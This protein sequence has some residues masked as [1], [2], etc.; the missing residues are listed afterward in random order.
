MQ[1]KS[2]W[3]EILSAT[4]LHL[5]DVSQVWL[6]KACLGALHSQMLYIYH[7]LLLLSSYD[8]VRKETEY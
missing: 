8:K 5:M 6:N 2:G 1:N 4:F 3:L 7:E